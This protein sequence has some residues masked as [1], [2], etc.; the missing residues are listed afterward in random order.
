MLCLIAQIATFI[1]GLV[2]T[3]TGK[4]SWS[5]TR[6]TRG[7][8]ARVAGVLLMMP[9]PVSFLIGIL[10]GLALV[11]QG[12][13]VVGPDDVPRWL[14]FME[15]AIYGIFVIAA[16]WVAGANAREEGQT[17][18]PDQY[19]PRARRGPGDE[20]GYDDRGYDDRMYDDRSP[21]Q[22][23]DDRIR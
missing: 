1:F 23:P 6:I 2:V 18:V 11:A 9:L 19:D 10:V 5:R 15:P 14:L 8:P 3:I 12:R 17:W 22:P 4:M 21:R 7:A 13:M 16:L 20:R